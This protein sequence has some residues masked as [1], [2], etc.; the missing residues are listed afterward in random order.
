MLHVQHRR[1]LIK[2]YGRN[3]NNPN[4]E[5]IQMIREYRQQID[6]RH[7]QTSELI[8]NHPICVSVPKCPL[9]RNENYQQKGYQRG[10]NA[11]QRKHSHP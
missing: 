4:Y 10:H 9:N 11:R 3:S 7:L 5:L 8:S 6:V 2:A 1:D